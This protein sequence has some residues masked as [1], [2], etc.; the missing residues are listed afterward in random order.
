MKKFFLFVFIACACNIHAQYGNQFADT[1]NGIVCLIHLPNTYYTD[2]G[3]TKYPLLMMCQ[4]RNEWGTDPI[5]ATKHGVGAAIKNGTWDG[6][7]VNPATGITEKFIA[8]STLSGTN[9]AP[10]GFTQ[11]DDL[12]T[13]LINTYR[14]DTSCLG[15]TGL[16]RGGQATVYYPT[17]VTYGNCCPS[18]F[19]YAIPSH[20]LAAIVPMSA[21]IQSTHPVDS[22]VDDSVW[23]WGFGSLSDGFGI[24]MNALVNHINA[25]APL[26]RFT[27]YAG[28][29][30]CW[31]P[32]YNASYKETI[33]GS[34]MNIYQFILYHRRHI[35]VTGAITGSPFCVSNAVG[36]SLS[37][38]FTSTGKYNS[39]N[40]YKAQLSDATG[41][42]ANPTVIGT[43]TSTANSGTISCVIPSGTS[44]GT[45]YKI[46]VRSTDPQF[47]GTKSSAI[48]INLAANSV[49][50]AGD[51]NIA[52]GQNGS[53]LTVTEQSAPLS[54]KWKYGTTI[55]N[56]NVD[57]GVTG[58]TYTPNFASAGTYY[59][60]CRSFYSCDT[61]TSNYVKIN[62]S[63]G[64]AGNNNAEQK[65]ALEATFAVH[66][67]SGYITC[68]YSVKEREKITITIYDEYG[69]TYASYKENKIAG[70][71][72][73]IFNRQLLQGLYIVVFQCNQQKF[74]SKRI[75]VSD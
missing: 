48:T 11:V 30:C 59:V 62:V 26:A 5:E 19:Q 42:F 27:S 47:F 60:V 52:A 14:V 3:S 7:A 63:A 17:H 64:F 65:L 39:G 45:G 72:S 13:Y 4:G 68:N 41:S 21:E 46:R 67:N 73:H 61:A 38:S 43:Y 32:F 15:L 10:L 55:G 8:V 34:L 29:H 58:I 40:I 75:L 50:P 28:G 51:Q 44:T 36:A 25:I 74:I 20:I 1:I 70:S 33:D 2:P 35:I 12:F 54:R 18:V 31:D 24:A 49:A 6:N 56:Y 69:R 71:Y 22:L 66:E 23:V 57:L 9:T 16:S 53:T 37:V